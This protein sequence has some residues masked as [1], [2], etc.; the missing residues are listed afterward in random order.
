M[1]RWEYGFLFL[2]CTTLLLDALSGEALLPVPRSIKANSERDVF[3]CRAKDLSAKVTFLADA[4]IPKE[5]YRA[6]VTKKGIRV[7]SSDAAGAFYA[8]RTLD[9]WA[10]KTYVPD[11]L[12]AKVKNRAYDFELEAVEIEDAPRFRWRGL[13]ID[14]ARHFLGKE[15]IFRQLELMAEYKLNVF[16]WH[17]VDDQGWRLDLPGHPELVRYGAVR[18][19]SVAYGAMTEWIGEEQSI[20][21]ELDSTRYGP[22]FYTPDEIREVLSFAKARHIT[23]VPEIELPGHERALLAAR[24]DLSCRGFALERVPRVYWSVEQDV[25]CAGND[26]AVR[27]LEGIFDEVCELFP[28]APYIHIGGDECPKDRWKTC[29]KCQARM[30]ELNAKDERDLQAWFTRHFVDYLGK[31]GR[32]AV[33]WDEVLH[34]NV[35]KGVVGM[36]W[37][38]SADNGARGDFVSAAEAAAR[39]HDIVLTPTDFCYFSRSSGLA[40]DP[41][42]YHIEAPYAEQ[43]LKRRQNFLSLAKAYSFDPNAFVDAK[44]Q[45]RVLGV[46][47]SVWSEAVFSRFDFEWKA[48]P[49]TCALAEI[50][51]SGP[52]ARPF[53]DFKQRMSAQRRRLLDRKVN[54]APLGED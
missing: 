37:R 10:K 25:L 1:K 18:P 11:P 3:M 45:A 44:H 8:V 53:S 42:P 21:Y 22:F 28:D 19:Q 9:Q 23:V 49:R 6:V 43:P 15:A 54:C 47:A 35:P 17:L 5:G 30:K 32:R 40:S 34:G 16:H 24:P 46:Q 20:H 50:A 2:F 27:Y 39:G 14:E 33:G 12:K 51:W 41:Y 4:S 29:P 31:K 48:W 26:E 7:W 36:I 13:M 52:K 38:M